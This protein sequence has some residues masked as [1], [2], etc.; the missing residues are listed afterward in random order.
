MKDTILSIIRHALT[1]AGAAL[2]AKGYLNT[3]SL[4][5]IVGA[6]IGLV[7][8]VW[9]PLDEFLAAKKAAIINSPSSV[10]ATAN[11]TAQ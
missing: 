4:N 11:T 1:G 3:S 5:E 9:G 2:V 7:G 8:A 6:A 10:T